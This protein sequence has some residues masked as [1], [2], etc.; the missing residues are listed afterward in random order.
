MTTIEKIP[1]EER[2]DTG[3]RARDRESLALCAACENA[4][5]GYETC[6]R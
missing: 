5:N 6:E 4:G 3:N 1:H 2:G